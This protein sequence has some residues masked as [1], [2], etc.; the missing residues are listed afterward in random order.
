[1]ASI[2]NSLYSFFFLSSD[3]LTAKRLVSDPVGWL[4]TPIILAKEIKAALGGL[5]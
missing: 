1:M 4:A 5:F 2:I 3:F